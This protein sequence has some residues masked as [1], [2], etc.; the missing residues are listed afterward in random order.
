MLISGDKEAYKEYM[1]ITRDHKETVVGQAH[2]NLELFELANHENFPGKN[3]LMRLTKEQMNYI[4][5]SANITLLT[6]W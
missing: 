1:N 5:I 3:Y 2:K 6:L 4:P